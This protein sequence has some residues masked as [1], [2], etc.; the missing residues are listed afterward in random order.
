M[1]LPVST[2]GIHEHPA[3]WKV[4]Q[5]GDAVQGVNVPVRLPWDAQAGLW[6]IQEPVWGSV[7]ALSIAA[8]EDYQIE[9]VLVIKNAG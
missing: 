3:L 7:Q 5:V 1:Q 6:H 2:R 4:F 9:H 8:M